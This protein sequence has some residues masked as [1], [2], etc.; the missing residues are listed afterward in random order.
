MIVK[1][2]GSYEFKKQKKANLISKQTVEITEKR[3]QNQK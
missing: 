2:T 3:S 1:K